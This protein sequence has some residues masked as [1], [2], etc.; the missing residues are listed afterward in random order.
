MRKRSYF[1]TCLIGIGLVLAACSDEDEALAP[2]EGVEITMT[3]P[4]DWDDAN[5]F[6]DPVVLVGTSP[7]EVG[8]DSF[9]ENVNVVTEEVPT[10]TLSSYY[11]AT[12]EALN[13]FQNFTLLSAKDTTLN[14]YVAKKIIFTA[15]TNQTTLQLMDYIL[16]EKETGIIVTCTAL[17][18]SFARYEAT[19]NQI[20]GT[21]QVN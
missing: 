15:E 12:L 17:E 7:P 18:K 20:A 13:N 11:D 16:Y 9:Y 14:G 1:I 10:L 4:D 2:K 19:F 8:S 21:I 6:G 5:R 3:F